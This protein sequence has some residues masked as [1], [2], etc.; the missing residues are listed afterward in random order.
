MDVRIGASGYRG[1][2]ASE[3]RIPDTLAAV[4]LHIEELVLHGFAPGDRFS[5]GDAIEHELS[6]L[7]SE[8]GLP[9]MAASSIDVARLDAGSFQIA[10]SGKAQAVGTQL[11]QQLYR[12]LSRGRTR[13]ARRQR[14]ETGSKQ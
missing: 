12:G 1:I 14:K 3:N 13:P 9:G 2:G 5:I 11:G 7:L 6:R 10:S 4:E 8:Q